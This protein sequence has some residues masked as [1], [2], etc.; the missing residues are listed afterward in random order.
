MQSR[1]KQL[2][3]AIILLTALGAWVHAA[4]AA[5]GKWTATGS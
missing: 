3:G 4:F 1:M 5:M 2:V